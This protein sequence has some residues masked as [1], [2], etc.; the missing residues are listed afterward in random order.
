MPVVIILPRPPEITISGWLVPAI[1]RVSKRSAK[2]LGPE[3]ARRRWS[4]RRILGERAAN[5]AIDRHRQSIEVVVN[6]AGCSWSF[7]VRK[8]DAL[9]DGD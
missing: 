3:V 4:C 8:V 6:A 7:P 2:R 5:W 1:R 9:N